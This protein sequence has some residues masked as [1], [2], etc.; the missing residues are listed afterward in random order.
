M[1]DEP[2]SVEAPPEQQQP[3]GAERQ[4]AP[5]APPPAPRS[6]ASSAEPA[7]EAADR[8]DP[9][10]VRDIGQLLDDLGVSAA[11]DDADADFVSED[12]EEGGDDELPEAVVEEDPAEVAEAQAAAEAA[13][14]T[15]AA[16]AAEAAPATE[17]APA[18]EAA[19]AT[20]AA[21]AAEA[22][23]DWPDEAKTRFSRLGAEERRFVLERLERANP[24]DADTEAQFQDI[25]ASY[26]DRRD[27]NRQLLAMYASYAR[28][29]VEFIRGLIQTHREQYRLTPEA[30]GF[31]ATPAAA[32]AGQPP[33][34]AADAP[35]QPAEAVS[36][37]GAQPAPAER[38]SLVALAKSIEID[39]MDTEEEQAKVRL[40]HE[41]AERLEETGAQLRQATEFAAQNR[42]RSE[43]EQFLSAVDA[44]GRSLHPHAQDPNVV[45]AMRLMAQEIPAFREKRATQND[46]HDLYLRAARL[47]GKTTAPRA[48]TKDPEVP[49]KPA[50]EAPP[51]RQPPGSRFPGA[52]VERQAREFSGGFR[53]PAQFDGSDSRDIAHLVD[54]AFPRLPA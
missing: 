52:K 27:L 35:Q 44:Q 30:V 22:P 42:T 37:Q 20:E 50:P 38:Q 34:A 15:E 49:P 51:R 40:L 28:T 17:A 18:A 33:A 31:G 39:P 46:L 4:D 41:M 19:P 5:V 9:Q 54:Q 13:P 29:P 7:A 48:P 23:A 6:E 1:P 53:I 45:E 16:P 36:A 32:A 21:P 12:G 14:A 10:E 8:A 43:A 24:F 11:E 47:T 2:V 3:A 25:L 26:P